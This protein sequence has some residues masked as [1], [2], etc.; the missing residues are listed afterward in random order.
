VGEAARTRSYDDAPDPQGT[1]VLPLV[2]DPA[3]PPRTPTSPRPVV[4]STDPAPRRRRNWL[5]AVGATL[6][7]VAAMVVAFEIGLQGDDGGDD[8]GASSGSSTSSSGSTSSEPDETPTEDGMTTFV[9]DYLATAVSDPA[10]AFDMLT[11]AFQERSGGIKGYEGFW[12]KVRSAKVL[13]ISADPEAGEVTYTYR[14]EQPPGGPHEDTV[15]L[16]LTFEDGT[17]LIDGEA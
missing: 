2:P 17:Y 1:Q 13:R 14:Y 8:P 7:V 9:Q 11:P 15:T 4:R 10:Q 12:G 16:R 5:I 6:A 3:T